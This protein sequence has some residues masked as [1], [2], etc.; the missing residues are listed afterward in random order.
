MG[1]SS[2]FEGRAKGIFVGLL[3]PLIAFL[4]RLGVN[5]NVLSIAG[6]FLNAAAGAA[7]GNGSFFSAALIVAAAGTC[8]VLDGQLA[9]ASGKVSAFGAFLDSTLDRIGEVFLFLGLAWYFSGGPSQS[10]SPLTIILII[11]A[12][13]GSLMVSYT[14]A[15]AEG[16]G[17]TCNAGLMRRPERMVLLIAGSLPGSLPETGLS[18]IKITIFLLAVL[19]NITVVQRIYHTR[20]RILNQSKTG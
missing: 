9:R 2:L 20:A 4:S 5:P 16:L 13:E 12:M 7:Y 17:V 10:Q 1:T 14:R 18:I 19:S 15:R 11:L 6:L 3:S 8:D